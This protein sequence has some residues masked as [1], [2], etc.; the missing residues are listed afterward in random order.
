MQYTDSATLCYNFRHISSI[1]PIRTTNLAFYVLILTGGYGMP[2]I[3]NFQYLQLDYILSIFDQGYA[4]NQNYR[5]QRAQ[6]KLFVYVRT[7]QLLLKHSTEYILNPHEGL[8]LTTD[9]AVNVFATVP[10]T[11]ALVIIFQATSEHLTALNGRTMAITQPQL[12][13]KISSESQT[14]LDLRR[15]KPEMSYDMEIGEYFIVTCASLYNHTTELLIS[16]CKMEIKQRLPATVSPEKATSPISATSNDP[17]E[18]LLYA[19]RISNT[20]YKQLLINQIKAYMKLNLDKPLTIQQLSQAFLISA[21][22]LKK[23]FKAETNTSIMAYFKTLRMTAAKE[24][25]SAQE[26]SFTQIAAQLGFSSVHH[27]SAAF[28]TYTGMTPSSY[29]KRIRNQSGK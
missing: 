5:Y 14:I 29:A 25:I 22:S 13:D 4:L 24:L 7:G 3:F 21:S 6:T 26:L 15:R 1:L 8:L 9:Q 18:Q 20:F 28:K 2:G 10:H 17:Q 16:L 27:F 19:R 23:S 11:T 12:I